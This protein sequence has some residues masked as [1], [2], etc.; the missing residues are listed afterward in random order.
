MWERG[1][2]PS[3]LISYRIVVAGALLQAAVV[4]N[5]AV[6]FDFQAEYGLSNQLVC[7]LSLVWF[8]LAW[9]QAGAT[10]SILDVGGGSSG[11]EQA[12]YLLTLCGIEDLALTPPPCLCRLKPSVTITQWR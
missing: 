9:S 7:V 4:P 3:S 6:P 8:R 5:S 1:E 10:V 2:G 12:F 11:Q